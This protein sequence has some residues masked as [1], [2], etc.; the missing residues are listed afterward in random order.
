MPGTSF[1][2]TTR[3]APSARASSVAVR[4]DPPRPSVVTLPSGARPMK[5]G[6]TAIV[7]ASRSG[8]STPAREPGGGGEVGRGAAVMAV[9]DDD[10][11]RVDVRRAPPRAR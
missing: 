9:G 10:L 3:F 1:Q 2:S 4:S 7:P 6:T 11:D 8:R 5:P